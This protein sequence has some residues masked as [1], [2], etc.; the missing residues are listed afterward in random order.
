[1]KFSIITP[2]YNKE[3][4]IAETIDS[5]LAQTYSDFE[6]II[7]NDSSTDRSADVVN[8]YNDSRIQL[9]TKPNGG[10]SAARNFGINRSG[11]DVV[12]FLDAD[13]MWQPDYLQ[14]LS[15][16]INQYPE[17]GLFCCAY[18]IFYQNK[19]NII[20]EKNLRILFEEDFKELD[21]IYTS[22]QM[23]GSIALTSAVSIRRSVLTKMDFWFDERYCIGEDNDMWTRASLLTKTLYCNK[24]MMCYRSES[25]GGLSISHY[26]FAKSIK[27]GE[28]YKLSNEKFLHQYA[29]LMAY[30]AA[31]ICYE[32]GLYRDAA[33]FLDEI[34]GP[35]FIL[36]RLAL[37]FVL[38]IKI[39]M[40]N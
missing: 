21:Y 13:D 10:V 28:W 18:N 7:V 4:F 11:G 23:R 1:M 30:C 17:S 31:R 27:Y 32:R 25:L 24:P 35:F 26:E 3:Q 14:T 22:L 12:C 2:L 34:K 5:V 29:S 15:Q 37:R 33:S 6:F 40:Y 8:S 20:R 38:K 36:R 9:Y 16:M 19:S 39:I